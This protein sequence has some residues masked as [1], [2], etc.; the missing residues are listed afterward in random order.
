MVCVQA[1]GPEQAAVYTAARQKVAEIYLHHKKDKR[2]F[3]VCY[4]ELVEKNPTP[5]AFVLLGDAYMSIEEPERA[6]EV[7][8]AALKR[9]PKDYAL[10]RKIGKAYVQ[11]HLYDK[12]TG[13]RSH[14]IY[15]R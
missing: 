6:I 11:A 1:I 13:T 3:A 14:F 4:K 15:L 5:A 2:Q 7:Y 9:N 12:V 8:E 10:A